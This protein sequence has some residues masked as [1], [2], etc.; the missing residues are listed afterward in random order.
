MTP[1]AA[2][3]N[4]PS[5]NAAY[6]TPQQQERRRMQQERDAAIRRALEETG[7]FTD[8]VRLDFDMGHERRERENDEEDRMMMLSAEEEDLNRAILLSLQTPV[9][10]A[11]SV[12]SGSTGTPSAETTGASQNVWS[13]VTVT[14]ENITTLENMGF[15]RDRAEAALRANR[16]NVSR[17]AEALLNEV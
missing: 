10:P 4:I 2:A 9:P 13:N 6:S 14:E 16:N 7:L 17:A 3:G 1:S 11:T 15:E 12:S 5:R 8:D